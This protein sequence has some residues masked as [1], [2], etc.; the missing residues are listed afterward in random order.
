MFWVSGKS[1]SNFAF[2]TSAFALSCA[3]RSATRWSTSALS[4]FYSAWAWAH[5]SLSPQPV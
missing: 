1:F 5:I 2:S 3:R 4:S